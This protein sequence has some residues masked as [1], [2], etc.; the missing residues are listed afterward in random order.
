M[1]LQGLE[2]W[3]Q[4]QGIYIGKSLVSIDIISSS[5][6]H[7]VSSLALGVLQS[8]RAVIDQSNFCHSSWRVS[9][10]ISWNSLSRNHAF[11]PI[12]FRSHV[13]IHWVLMMG[14]VPFS[15]SVSPHRDRV[16]FE[17]HSEAVIVWV[18]RYTWRLWYSKFGDEIGGRNGAKLQNVI[19]PVWR[20]TWRLWSSEYWDALQGRDRTSLEMNLDGRNGSNLEAIIERVWSYASR[21]WLSELGHALGGCAWTRLHEYLVVVDGRSTGWWVSIYWWPRNGG[22]VENWVQ[23]GLRRDER[24]AGSGRKLVLG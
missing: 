21:L 18:W 14:C 4:Q 23:L 12:P 2:S 3:T 5:E 15:S 17:M 10:H 19:E 7:N 24:L 22:I 1:E 9:L 16:N 11:S 13:R 8:C 6:I 20:Y